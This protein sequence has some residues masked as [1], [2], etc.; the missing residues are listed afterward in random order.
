MGALRRPLFAQAFCLLLAFEAGLGP[1]LRFAMNSRKSEQLLKLPVSYAQTAFKARLPGGDAVVQKCLSRSKGQLLQ[2]MAKGCGDW[3][4]EVIDAEKG[5]YTIAHPDGKWCAPRN[6]GRVAL[7]GPKLDA[8][9]EDIHHEPCRPFPKPLPTGARHSPR[10]RVRAKLMN[11]EQ[12]AVGTVS[13]PFLQP[14]VFNVSV[15]ANITVELGFSSHGPDREQD[16]Q[17]LLGLDGDLDVWLPNFPG[18][19][20]LMSLFFPVYC[21]IACGGAAEG[22]ARCYTNSPA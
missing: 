1:R 5:R 6:L 7:T 2:D 10:V 19:S 9:L 13:L 22:L 17:I 11:G 3:H 20:T 21:R 15:D 12:L 4:V 14:Y 8:C 18:V 16:A